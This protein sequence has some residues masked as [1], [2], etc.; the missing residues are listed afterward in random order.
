[1]SW[2]PSTY[3]VSKFYAIF[4]RFL[5]SFSSILILSFSK[6]HWNLTPPPLLQNADVLNG[7]P[8]AGLNVSEWGQKSYCHKS[9][10][11]PMHCGTFVW[12]SMTAIAVLFL[13]PF[14]LFKGFFVTVDFCPVMFSA[15]FFSLIMDFL[16]AL[17]G[18][19]ENLAW[20]MIFVH[21]LEMFKTPKKVR[22]ASRLSWHSGNMH[23]SS[24]H[25]LNFVYLLSHFDWIYYPEIHYL[26]SDF[27]THD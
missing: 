1:M 25:E 19:N 11:C 23:F 27:S 24:R 7:C 14:Y 8:L 16:P 5:I 20:I 15:T 21:K 13:T 6:F 17:K 26:V 3:Y 18:S 10:T 22:T 2:G 9:S 4:D 12:L